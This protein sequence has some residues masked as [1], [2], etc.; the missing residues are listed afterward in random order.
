MLSVIVQSLTDANLDLQ[1]EKAHKALTDLSASLG[2][3]NIPFYL[4][5]IPDEKT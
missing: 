1:D 5:H 3:A 4:L 2:Y